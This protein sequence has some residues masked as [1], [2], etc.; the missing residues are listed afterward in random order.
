[1]VMVYLA[2]KYAGYTRADHFNTTSILPLKICPVIISQSILY[3]QK[4]CG[5]RGV[6]R[7]KDSSAD[8]TS[9]FP[10]MSESSNLNIF[11][12]VLAGY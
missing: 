4:M 1:M 10:V 11:M 5:P 8:L 6:C 7:K 2:Q 9:Y 3:L 12:S